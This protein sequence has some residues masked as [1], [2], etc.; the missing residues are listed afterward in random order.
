MRPHS[1]KPKKFSEGINADS[2]NK[3]PKIE[4]VFLAKRENAGDGAGCRKPAF[5]RRPPG[6]RNGRKWLCG[7]EKGGC[8]RIW[9]WYT[10]TANPGSRQRRPRSGRQ[11][12]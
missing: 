5:S 6:G 11:F 10:D 9:L 12:S 3:S 4:H 1:E 8:K 7:G 2:K